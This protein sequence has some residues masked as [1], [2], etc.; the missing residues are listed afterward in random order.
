MSDKK[1]L[2]SMEKSLKEREKKIEE[3]KK[4]LQAE[5]DKLKNQGE[6]LKVLQALKIE[7]VDDLQQYIGTPPKAQNKIFNDDEKKPKK[8][9]GLEDRVARIEK[10]QEKKEALTR[11]NTLAKKLREVV[12]AN[13]DK[14]KH[15]EHLSR[16]SNNVLYSIIDKAEDFFKKTGKQPDPHVFL[17][18]GEKL[19]QETLKNH[20][21]SLADV[22]N[23]PP[24]EEKKE[25]KEEEKSEEEEKEKEEKEEKKDENILEKDGKKFKKLSEEEIDKLSQ[26][27]QL[28][29]YENED[30]FEGKDTNLNAPHEELLHKDNVAED[31]VAE[32]NVA[33]EE[34]KTEEKTDEKNSEKKS[35]KNSDEKK[36]VTISQSTKSSL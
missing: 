9:K 31:N 8:E 25:E 6:A 36:S 32:D 12:V 23:K 1:E 15:L 28:K 2:E 19:S 30:Y 13:K 34:K 26:E 22:D 16:K 11:I 4:S 21:L 14:Y 24:E 5:K 33:E 3:E 7:S 27:D 17:E 35:E 20:G 10:E 18:E 29:Y